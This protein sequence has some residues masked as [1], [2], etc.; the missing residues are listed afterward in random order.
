MPAADL[1]HVSVWVVWC[2]GRP[3]GRAGPAAVSRGGQAR[4]PDLPAACPAV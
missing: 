2:P 3:A 1:L 4:P